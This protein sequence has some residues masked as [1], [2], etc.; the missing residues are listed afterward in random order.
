MSDGELDE[1]YSVSQSSSTSS[2]LTTLPTPSLPRSIDATITDNDSN[3]VKAFKMFGLKLQNIDI[4]EDLHLVDNDNSESDLESNENYMFENVVGHTIEIENILPVHFR[5]F[6]HTLNLCATTDINKVIK[7]SVELS[8]IHDQVIKKMLIRI[9]QKTADEIFI[10][11]STHLELE[12]SPKNQTTD[13]FFDFGS[14]TLTI[15]MTLLLRPDKMHDKLI[16]YAENLL[17][18]FVKTFQNIYGDHLASHNIHGLLHICDDYRRFGPLDLCS[19]FPFENFMKTLKYM[20]RKNEKPLEQVNK[21][22][23]E[24]CKNEVFK[25]DFLQ[26]VILSNKHC[27]GPSVENIC[28]PQYLRE[29]L[30]KW[31]ILHI[32]NLT[33]EPVIIGFMFKNKQQLYNKPIRSTKLNIFILNDISN[34][35]LCHWWKNGY[36]AWPNTSVKH[37]LLLLQKR[38][39]PNKFDFNFF[40]ARIIHTK[41]PIKSYVDAKKRARKA[42]FTSELSSAEE[43]QTNSRSNKYSRR[44]ISPPVFSD[45]DDEYKN[46]SLENNHC[47][48][49]PE[50]IISKRKKFIK[51]DSQVLSDCENMNDRSQSKSQQYIKSGHQ[52]LSDIQFENYDSDEIIGNEDDSDIDKTYEPSNH[53]K[54]EINTHL[55]IIQSPVGSWKVHSVSDDVI[56]SQNLNDDQNKKQFKHKTPEMNKV[57][58]RLFISTNSDVLETEYSN[59]N[60]KTGF[61]SFVKSSLTNLKYDL[62]LLSRSIDS[63]KTIIQSIKVNTSH[64]SS[65]NSEHNNIMDIQEL[66]WPISNSTQLDVD[67][68]L[69]TD[70]NIKKNEV[71]YSYILVGKSISESIRR[72]MSKMFE[73][74]FL[75]QYSFT[76][77]KGRSKFHGLNCCQLLFVFISDVL[78]NDKKFNATPD[79]EISTVAAKWLAQ[80]TNRVT[81]KKKIV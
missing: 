65:I 38:A 47:N 61:V 80:A 3:F 74:S 11:K 44:S 17:I 5:C 45:T 8:L 6:A 20:L 54:N 18:Y 15:A 27:N 14:S 79:H 39:I 26:D 19:C 37:S 55:E 28:G 60:N 63:L 68:Q 49:Q 52:V 1:G 29:K 58:K 67:E 77:F 30:Y 73:D 78:R 62:K 2:S 81:K 41:N 56:D 36:S 43:S 31:K 24:K 23:E 42:Q 32:S 57:K 76:G 25:T 46:K 16:S 34:N 64:I 70:T 12:K 50:S 59:L 13:D 48:C 9:F 21:R 4:V 72:M 71:R 33:K 53:D 35:L 75:Q 7:S 51:F 40:I 22:H 69:L 10:E 66:I